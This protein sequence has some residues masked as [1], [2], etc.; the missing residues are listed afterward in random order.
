[1]DSGALMLEGIKET[2]LTAGV[3]WLYNGKET[4]TVEDNTIKE[5][6]EYYSII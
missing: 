5:C 3:L 4:A 6:P 2:V 1:M